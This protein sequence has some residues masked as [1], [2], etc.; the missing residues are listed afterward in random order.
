MTE[1]DELREAMEQGFAR[2]DGRIDRLG[3][4]VDDRFDAVDRDHQAAKQSAERN[5]RWIRFVGV[6]ATFLAG[7]GAFLTPIIVVLLSKP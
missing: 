5:A 2:L 3:E 4:R 6:L 7:L 1:V